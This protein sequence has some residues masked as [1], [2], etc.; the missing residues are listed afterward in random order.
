MEVGIKDIASYIP[1]EG[2]DNIEQGL[3]FGESRE[4]VESKLGPYF[5]PRKSTDQDCSDLCV[6]AIENLVSKNENFNKNDV[7]LVVVVTQNGDEEKL[8]HT[9]A[10]VQKKAGLPKSVAAF[11][12]SLGCSGY[13]HGL[14]AVKG[15]MQAAGLENALLITSDP[16]SKII[17]PNDRTTAMLFGDAATATW[18]GAQPK[19]K[20]GSALFG[21]DGHGADA[22]RV[23]DGVF[24]MNGRQVFNF[25]SINV[26][27]QIKELLVK[28]D[29]DESDVDAYILHQGSAAIIDAI[30]KR[31]SKPERFIKN[32]GATG[33][34]VS[35]SIPLLIEQY[36]MNSDWNKIVLSG[37]GVGLSWSSAVIY[38]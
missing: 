9:A 20:I 38:K 19:F 22:L 14:Y 8:P 13:V 16:Y 2:I 28:S 21:T 33:N 15:F 5:L 25:A 32:I 27:K 17:D 4:F 31:F 7:Q 23:K 3:K 6:A 36:A 1:S 34:T 11:D 29:Y 37:F 35:S 10:L 30:A 24:S 26:P 18:I 12:L